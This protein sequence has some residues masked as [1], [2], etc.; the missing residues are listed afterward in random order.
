[1]SLADDGSDDG[2]LSPSPDALLLAG[3]RGGAYGSMGGGTSVAGS[4]GGDGG[5]VGSDAGSAAPGAA[6]LA[7][8]YSGAR[9]R[10]GSVAGGSDKG[11]VVLSPSELARYEDFFGGGGSEAGSGGALDEGRS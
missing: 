10:R 4:A 6:A 2:G 5:S 3:R 1:L 7:R 8:L 9:S 11:S